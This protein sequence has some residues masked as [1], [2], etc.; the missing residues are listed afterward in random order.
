MI[1][2]LLLALALFIALLY[3]GRGYWAWVCAVIFALAA[4]ATRGIGSPTLFVVIAAIAA[5]AALIFGNA[6]L[7]RRLVS[8]RLMR[9]FAAML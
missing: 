9:L 8:G 1:L 2:I 4:W 5:A 3:L 7:R 6:G